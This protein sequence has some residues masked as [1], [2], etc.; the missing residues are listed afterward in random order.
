[1]DLE[2]SGDKW[3]SFYEVRLQ[4]IHEREKLG[5]KNV[6]MLDP[7][8]RPPCFKEALAVRGEA[9]IGN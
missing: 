7:G 1:M 9:H 8:I 2:G 6:G 4:P 3:N 5:S